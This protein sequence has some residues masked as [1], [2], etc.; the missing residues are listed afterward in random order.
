[1]KSETGPWVFK[2]ANEIRWLLEHPLP[3]FLCV[4]DKKTLRLE[5]YHTSPRFHLWAS[6]A[7]P[8]RLELSFADG[9]DGCN[10]QYSGDDEHFSLS[11]PIW[12]A[13]LVELQNTE[14]QEAF[15]KVMRAWI[16]VE[17][18]NLHRIRSG[19]N[20][21]SM[22]AKYKTNDPDIF[23]GGEVFQGTI[24][25]PDLSVA[26]RNVGECV[27]SLSGHLYRKGDLAGAARCALLLRHLFPDDT[28]MSWD[29]YPLQEAING[30]TGSSGY[31]FAGVDALSRLINEQLDGMMQVGAPEI[32]TR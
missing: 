4:V 13:T 15:G 17:V 31:V 32:G 18:S 29:T 24:R 11:V 1:V 8:E 10:T 19:V 7:K 14:V 16:G 3:L 27:N 6:A 25:V 26:T 2:D 23:R 9:V 30:A 12:S 21:Y 5:V 28:A 22:P 20:L